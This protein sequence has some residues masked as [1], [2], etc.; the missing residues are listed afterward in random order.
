MEI[1]RSYLQ[2][3]EAPHFFPGQIFSISLSVFDNCRTQSFGFYDAT[4]ASTSAAQALNAVRFSRK[5]S[6]LS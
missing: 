1:E 4:M 3:I 5:Y 6:F 2:C